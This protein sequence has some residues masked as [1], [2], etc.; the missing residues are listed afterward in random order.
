MC[1]YIHMWVYVGLLYSH[2]VSRQEVCTY[3]AQE[4]LGLT[5]TM[6]HHTPSH[7]SSQHPWVKELVNIKIMLLLRRDLVRECQ[8]L[9]LTS[10]ICDWERE[11]TA[12]GWLEA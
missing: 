8:H 10:H 1:I 7:L 6:Q 5:S 4:K 2:L 3:V 9:D 12:G 11:I